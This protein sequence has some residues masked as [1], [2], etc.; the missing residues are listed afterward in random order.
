MSGLIIIKPTSIT[1]SGLSSSI[2]QG[3][4]VDFSEVTSLALDGIFSGTY[5]NYQLHI[6][7]TALGTTTVTGNL[8]SSGS[9]ISTA[10]YSNVNIEGI[11]NTLGGTRVTGATQWNIMDVYGRGTVG[12]T[13]TVFCPGIARPTAIICKNAPDNNRASFG[14]RVGF[15]SDLVAYTGFRI[16]SLVK[17]SGQI[18]VYGLREG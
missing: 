9:D 12:S 18:T 8:R 4:T 7:V 3:G 1:A 6:A 16:V 5:T 15:Q 2:R 17:L 10:T 13:L 11:V 14:D